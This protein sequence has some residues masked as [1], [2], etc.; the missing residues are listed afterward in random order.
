[1]QEQ[2]SAFLLFISIKEESRYS[3]LIGVL[4]E[5]LGVY[6]C[7]QQPFVPIK[8]H[9]YLPIYVL[10]QHFALK[11]RKIFTFAMCFCIKI[12]LSAF[13][14]ISRQSPTCSQ[15][16][17]SCPTIVLDN[18]GAQVEEKTRCAKHIPDFFAGRKAPSEI[19]SSSLSCVCTFLLPS[20]KHFCAGDTQG[21]WEWHLPSEFPKCFISHS[22]WHPER[23]WL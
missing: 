15:Q 13:L 5:Y 8:Q 14:A 11:P 21:S 9:K 10:Q 6:S 12:L 23:L 2:R 4:M 18:L 16:R 3:R 1:M 17:S 7:R 20:C 22:L 19:P